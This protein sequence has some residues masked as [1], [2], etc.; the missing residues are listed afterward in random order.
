MPRKPAPDSRERILDTASRLFYE[1]GVHAVGVQQVI[2]ECGCGKNLLYREF[3]SKDDLL[4]AYLERSRQVWDAK[5]SALTQLHAGNPAGQLLALVRRAVEDA[6][7]PNFY[8]CP[9][10][11]SV[12]EYPDESHPVREVVTKQRIAMLA[13]IR[14]IAAEGGAHNADALAARIVLIMDGINANG[15]VLG[16]QG[17]ASFAEAFAEDVVRDGFTPRN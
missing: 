4:L 3:P 14:Q 7:D 8:G 10:S 15:A 5:L 2:D 6:A 9:F 1:N 11:K 13:S 16:G 17:S 12:A